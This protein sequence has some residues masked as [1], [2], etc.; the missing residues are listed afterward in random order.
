MK[1]KVSVLVLWAAAAALAGEIVGWA[2]AQPGHTQHRLVGHY[3]R[4]AWET[5][6]GAV[7]HPAY[8][9]FVLALAVLQWL[10][11]A[12]KSQ[13]RPSLAVVQDAFWFLF[14]TAMEREVERHWHDL[15]PA[16]R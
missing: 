14:T 1:S 5:W 4:P 2:M 15:L 11:P 3:I 16:A 13:R 8:W 7:L 9:A 12:E 10:W 6:L